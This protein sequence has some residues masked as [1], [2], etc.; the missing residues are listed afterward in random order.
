M[1]LDQLFKQQLSPGELAVECEV[2]FAMVAHVARLN[3]T[4]GECGSKKAVDISW[5]GDNPASGFF[6]L[7]FKIFSTDPKNQKFYRS[8]QILGE[9]SASHKK[10]IELP[11]DVPARIKAVKMFLEQFGWEYLGPIPVGSIWRYEIGLKFSQNWA[12]VGL[13][14][15]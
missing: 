14:D 2:H 5:R 15:G 6:E 8:G 4:G 1:T 3:L 12:V 7:H 11:Q 10:E 13:W 9:P